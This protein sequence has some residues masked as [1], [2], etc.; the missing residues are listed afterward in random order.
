MTQKNKKS[1][2]APVSSDP[3]IT[4]PQILASARGNPVWTRYLRAE[5]VIGRTNR[6]KT[7]GEFALESVLE[8]CTQ[9]VALNQQADLPATVLVL[10][11]KLMIQSYANFL[12]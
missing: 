10:A 8:C 7:A 6:A 12:P 2:T 3:Q 11:Q 9:C 1:L 5:S 4:R